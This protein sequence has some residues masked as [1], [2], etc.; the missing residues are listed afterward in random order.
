MYTDQ[1]TTTKRLSSP[2]ELRFARDQKKC[3][4]VQK[5]RRPCQRA[6]KPRFSAFG[7]QVLH[8]QHGAQ[9]ARQSHR[10]TQDTA[11]QIPPATENNKCGRCRIRGREHIRQVATIGPNKTDHHSCSGHV[12]TGEGQTENSE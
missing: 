9:E 11:V 5:P 6:G 3:T 7:S 12:S 10:N 8:R 2:T 1:E 4:H